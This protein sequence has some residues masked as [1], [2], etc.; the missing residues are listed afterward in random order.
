M[1]DTKIWVICG[2]ISGEREVSL[3]SGTNVYESVLRLGYKDAELLDWKDNGALI[4]LIKAKDANKIDKAILVTHGN[5]G[6][7]GCIQ[8]LLEIL[9]VPYTGSNHESSA[10]CMNKTRTKEILGFYGLPV[11]PSYEASRLIREEVLEKNFILK[12]RASGSSVGITKFDT[13]DKFLEFY[14]KDKAF[15]ENI[16]NYFIEPFINGIE[17]TTSIIETKSFDRNFGSNSYELS[18]ENLVSLPLLE[19]RPKN[20]FYD[21]EAKYT[22]GMTEFIIP[23]ELNS[24]MTETLHKAALE[25]FRILKCKTCA[26][27]DFL[28]DKE[29]KKPYILEVNTLPGMTNTSDM[30]AQAKA[31]GI[32]YDELVQAII[33]SI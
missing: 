28:I 15:Q 22:E 9:G 5:Y 12:P 33:D 7:D 1:K 13:R 14:N 21:Y 25:A 8:G 6:E 20:E 17:V 4:K 18:S 29:T 16:E 32:S 30:P 26:R 10:I 2:G 24:E 31:A 27:V 11:L 23:A 3:R 19:L